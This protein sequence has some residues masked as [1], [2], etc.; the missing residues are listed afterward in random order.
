[1]G[2][3]SSE[4]IYALGVALGGVTVAAG[5]QCNGRGPVALSTMPITLVVLFGFLGL[6]FGVGYAIRKRKSRMRRR[7]Y[8]HD[9]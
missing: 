8:Y 5:T 6:G 2:G 3:A 9:D 4:T 7:S 1:M